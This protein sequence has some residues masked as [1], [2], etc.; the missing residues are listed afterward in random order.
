MTDRQTPCWRGLTG[1]AVAFRT[2][3]RLISVALV[4]TAHKARARYSF[5]LRSRISTGSVPPMNIGRA[6]LN[7][8]RRKADS[9]LVHAEPHPTFHGSGWQLE[10]VGDLGVR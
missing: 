10:P 9:E 4:R 8:D 7:I 6:E 1:R 3:L 2:Y 5:V